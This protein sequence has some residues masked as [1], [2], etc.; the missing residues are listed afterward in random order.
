M[1]I[2]YKIF[3]DLGLLLII[4]CAPMPVQSDDPPEYA[5][6][7]E[8]HMAGYDY[9]KNGVFY[10]YKFSSYTEHIPNVEEKLVD[11]H[12]K[13]IVVL[14]AWYQRGSAMCVPPGGKKGMNVIVMPK[15]IVR[16]KK[17]NSKVL[18]YNF[19]F[20]E[21]PSTILCGYYV[22]RYHCSPVKK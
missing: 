20:T 4:G 2:T 10:E 11:F 7:K 16:L 6:I 3:I 5:V 13:G 17:Q 22:T 18:S 15:F 21:K 1:S 8:N 12:A 14:D 9:P 19:K